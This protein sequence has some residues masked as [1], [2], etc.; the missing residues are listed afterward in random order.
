[1]LLNNCEKTALRRLHR[2]LIV[3]LMALKII[4]FKEQRRFAV[5]GPV[6]VS[7]VLLVKIHKKKI[8]GW[9]Y[10]SQIDDSSYKICK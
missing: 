7:M 5:T 9:A 6:M 10:V 8:P 2:K 3:Q 4:Y 1:M